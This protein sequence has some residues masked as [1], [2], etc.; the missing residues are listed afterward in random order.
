MTNYFQQREEEEKTIP[1][2]RGFRPAPEE[3]TLGRNP[4][5]LRWAKL[6]VGDI[7]T[8]QNLQGGKLTTSFLVLSNKKQKISFLKIA[9]NVKRDKAYLDLEYLYCESILREGQVCNSLLDLQR[10][11]VGL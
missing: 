10:I 5:K 8:Y 1:A 11:E 9:E 2:F 3:K 4:L 7:V 6:I